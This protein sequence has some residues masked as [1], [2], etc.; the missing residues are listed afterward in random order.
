M[1][2]RTVS[3]VN[4]CAANNPGSFLTF[5]MIVKRAKVTTGPRDTQHHGC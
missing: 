1:R 3:D 5:A 2:D 4:A